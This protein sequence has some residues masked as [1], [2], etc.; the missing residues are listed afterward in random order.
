MSD[1]KTDQLGYPA[2]V[3]KAFD[4][5]G[6]VLAVCGMDVRL[7]ALSAD[8]L[9]QRNLEMERCP[10]EEAIAMEGGKIDH[11]GA[12]YFDPNFVWEES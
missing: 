6:N 12:A 10:Y 5:D 9:W 2:M 8:G 7:F 1:E 11:W 4:A 3:Q